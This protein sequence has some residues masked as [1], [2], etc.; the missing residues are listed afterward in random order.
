MIAALTRAQVRRIDQLALDRYG[1]SGLVLMENAGRN[2]AEVIHSSFGDTRCAVLFCGMGNNGGDGFVITRHLRNV[3]WET[4]IVLT[5]DPQRMTSSAAANYKTVDAMGV[6]LS[7]V[8]QSPAI[9]PGE[10]VIDAMLGTGFQG[11]VRSPVDEMI[12]AVN[13]ANS[14]GVVAIDI[15]SGL[16]CDTGQPSNVTIR[17][18]LTITFV[19]PKVGFSVTGAQ[20][21]LGHVVPVPIGVPCE[22]IDWVTSDMLADDQL[23]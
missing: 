23:R 2:A 7:P 20:T 18:S 17:A 4:R 14:R 15:P 13:D 5:G 3:G 6:D 11:D 8:T 12:R 21:Y 10:L 22:L 19:A 9:E 1:L 16:N